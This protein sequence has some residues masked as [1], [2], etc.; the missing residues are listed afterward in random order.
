MKKGRPGILLSVLAAA[1]GLQPL[2]EAILKET[3]TLGVR[4]Y[5]AR[6]KKLKR[7]QRRFKSSL[8]VVTVKEAWYQGTSRVAPEYEDCARIAKRKRISLLKVF[9]TIEKEWAEKR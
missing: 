2:S 8:G 1:D 5:P 4:Y 7:K 9:K 3:S 6:R